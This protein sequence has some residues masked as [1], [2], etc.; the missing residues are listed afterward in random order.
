MFNRREVIKT[1]AA[2]AAVTA[3]VGASAAN[4]AETIE[5]F[6]DPENLTQKQKDM[7]KIRF[8]TLDGESHQ[9]F[10]TGFKKFMTRQESNP[11]SVARTEAH[12]RAH[13]LSML[14]DTDLSYETCWNI[15]MEDPQYA[16][17]MRMDSTGQHIMWDRAR[18]VFAKNSGYYMKLLAD[19]ENAGPGKLELNPNLVIPDYAR[20]EIHAEP[21]GYVGDPLGGWVYHYAVTQGYR[22]GAAYHDENHITY[23]NG[24]VKPA[25]GVVKRM[26]DLGCGTG[27]STTPLKMRFP[28]TEVWGLDVG[29]PLVRYAH[30]RARKMGLDVN[31][32]HGL[33]EDT[34]F[35]D[36]H[37]DMVSSTIVFHEVDANAAKKI[38]KEIYR[39]TR[40]GGTYS[41]SDTITMGHPTRHPAST[42]TGKAGIWRGHRHHSYEPWFLEYTDS[43][44]PQVM[45]DAGFNVDL[46]LK[47]IG[48]R[49]RW[50]ATK[51]V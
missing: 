44:F 13:K 12:L 34:K 18:R 6:V 39:I 2:A 22:A 15:L 17:N 19:A 1:T 25:D 11:E 40:P 50:I 41:H 38:V 36:N 24:H 32:R 20:H 9:D 16:V 42:V 26:I 47:P 14:D 45:A 21:G 29:A 33:A 23:A 48:G 7:L 37:F 31:F 35:P 28:N 51:P 3:I 30:Y 46:S 5:V 4:A 27:Q 8:D 43:N 49:Q 10:V